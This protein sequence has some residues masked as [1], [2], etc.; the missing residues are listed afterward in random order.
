M[1]YFL[2]DAHLGLL[3]ISDPRE[4]E[5]KLVRFLD[6]IKQNAEEVYLLGDM[7]DFWF[8][9]KKVI[10]QGFTRFLGKLAEL[11]DAGIPVHF[12]TGNHDLWTFGYLEKEIGLIVHRR[13]ELVEL[14]GKMFFL[15]HGDGLNDTGK[16]F[17]L[18][19]KIF[20]SRTCQK[21]FSYFPPRLGMTFG[22]LWS[23][24]NREKHSTYDNVYLGEDK[25]I[26]I[27]FAKQYSEHTAVDY[28]LF[29]H[30]HLMFDLQL[31]NKSRVVLLG[32]WI[33]QYSYAVFDGKELTVEQF[34]S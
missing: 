6:S 8:E 18:L 17:K 11:T 28:F 2:S 31:K 30:R 33:T 12:F 16:S 26:L 23:K 29:G 7:F 9:Y 20:H 13:P 34:L 3:S 27:Q 15:A 19:R 14:G 24:N 21:L 25:E 1:I 10:P 22:Q 32:D 4:H 5:I